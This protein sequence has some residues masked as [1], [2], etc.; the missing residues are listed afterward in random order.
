MKAALIQPHFS[1]LPEEGETCFQAIL[2]DLDACDPS[3]DLIVLPEYSDMPYLPANSGDYFDA[4]PKHNA[5]L[6]EK[7]RETAVRCQAIVFCNC[8]DFTENGPRN[9]TFAIGRNGETLGKYYKRHLAPSEV[10]MHDHKGRRMDT[11]YANEP[12]SPFVLTIDGLRFGFM[13]CFDFYFYEAFSGIARE[14]V[15][16]I[17]GCSLQRPAPHS[18]LE[19]INRFLCLE[20]NA[21]LLRAGVS[22]SEDSKTCGC[23]MAVSPGGKVL[24][25]MKNRVGIGTV[26]FDPSVKYLPN[27]G[28]DG[29]PAPHHEYTEASRRPWFY[30]PAGPMMIPGDT[31]LPY[32]RLSAHRGFHAAAPENSLPAFGAAVA[33]GAEEIAFDLWA[34]KDGH[35]VSVQDESLERVSNGTGKVYDRTLEELQTLDFGVKYGEAFR[36]LKVLTFEEILRKFARTVVMNVHVRQWDRPELPPYYEKIRELIRRYDCEEHVYVTSKVSAALERFH[37]L[38]PKIRRCLRFDGQSSVDE[39]IRL[40]C[41]KV[42]FSKLHIT[43]E[44]VDRAHAAM[45]RCSVFYA[46]DP[47]EA[48]RD[49]DMGVD[50][51]LTNDYQRVKAGLGR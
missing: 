18:M 45:L 40:G 17:I 47:S 2:D 30:R 28:P 7:I 36:G 33:L 10:R 19:I 15:D 42:E 13:T 9:T 8:Y 37:E 41:E 38:A 29:A 25:N 48:Q 11:A 39:A 3:L 24:L 43:K 44:D 1:Y 49:L 34:T 12:D 46:D 5:A 22:L 32:P 50:T 51:V 23:S 31:S 4:V 26:E 16:V 20:T 27:K 35:F 6:M 21:Y 14:N